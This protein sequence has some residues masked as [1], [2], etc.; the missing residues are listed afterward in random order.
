MPFGPFPIIL[1]IAMK[2]P[3]ILITN[4]DGIHSPGLLQ[5]AQSLKDLAEI[6][7]VAPADEKSG[8]SLSISVFHPLEVKD[9]PFPDDIKAFQV[10]GT[11]ADCVKVALMLIMQERPDFIASGINPSSNAGRAVLYSG[12]LG[13]IIEGC[14]QGI[15][16]IG[17]SCV[18]EKNPQYEK[19][20][21]FIPLLVEHFIQE[22]LPQ[23]TIL[24][25]NFPDRD[26][27]SGIKMARQGVENWLDD[28]KEI[29]HE[30]GEVKYKLTGKWAPDGWHEESDYFLLQQGYITVVPIH[31]HELT[32]HQTLLDRKQTFENAFKNHF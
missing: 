20:S 13:G 24:N 14:F 3:K 5:L 7:V 21:H 4:D 27:F 23:G 6:T 18:E 32:C 11:P 19:F 17:F 12:T 16:G 10:S 25:V 22:S 2:K 29:K 8:S 9:V 1:G 31:V 15:P 26:T 30:N 28:Y